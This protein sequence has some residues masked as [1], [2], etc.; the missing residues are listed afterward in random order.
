MDATKI[1]S[2]WKDEQF[3]RT[4]SAQELTALP[5]SPVGLIELSD[6]QL[7]GQ[8]SSDDVTITYLPPTVTACPDTSSLICTTISATVILPYETVDN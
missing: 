7:C 4:L 5:E 8:Q 2:S 1:I 3:R 6:N